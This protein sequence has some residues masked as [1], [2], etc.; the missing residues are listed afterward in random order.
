MLKKCLCMTLCAVLCMML[1]CGNAAASFENTYTLTG[2]AAAD[3]VGVAMT[4]VGYWE[5]SLEGDAYGDWDNYQKYGVWYDEN[6]EYIGVSTA[7]WSAA[8]VSWCANEAG[9]PSS[10]L[11]YHAYCPYGVNWFKKQGV[12]YAS[13]SRG[14]E[15]IPQMGD[16]IYF[17]PASSEV[18]TQV[19]IVTEVKNGYVYVIQGNTTPMNG[20]PE[21][22]GVLRKQYSLS[23]VR[24]Y[25]YAAPAYDTMPE[26]VNDVDG[27]GIMNTTDARAVLQCAIG[28]VTLTQ[29]QLAIADYDGDGEVTTAD[30]RDLLRELLVA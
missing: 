7:A 27:D 2:D 3:L 8:F 30:A 16:L 18:C 22:N 14:G 4:Q 21:A 9:I 29:A 1:L 20:E 23:Y 15:Y 17:A 11:Y 5:G 24:I 12:F 6:V 25:G 13:A 28:G 10:V 26:K 19:G